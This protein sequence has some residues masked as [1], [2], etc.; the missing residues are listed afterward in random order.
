[1]AENR[2]KRHIGSSRQRGIE[3]H[4][5]TVGMHP[6]D[7]IFFEGERIREEPRRHRFASIMPVTAFALQH[8]HRAIGADPNPAQWVARGPAGNVGYPGKISEKLRILLETMAAFP[9]PENLSADVEID[10][11]IERK[12]LGPTFRYPVVLTVRFH[13]RLAID[14]PYAN[15]FRVT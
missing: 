6:D 1:M 9:K 8:M 11:T 5:T 14:H 15:R 7:A 4:Q 3:T 13:E 12:Y 2:P 10:V